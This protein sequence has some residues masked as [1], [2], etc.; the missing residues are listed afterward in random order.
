MEYRRYEND[1]FES[2]APG[3]PPHEGRGGHGRPHGR[4]RGRGRMLAYFL[5]LIVLNLLLA[6]YALYAVGMSMDMDATALLGESSHTVTEMFFQILMLA[7]PILLSVILNRILYWLFGGRRVFP[8]GTGVLAFLVILLVQVLTV[9]AVLRYGRVN[10]EKG[11]APIVTQI[12][13]LA[14]DT[15]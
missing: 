11:F 1:G 7:S 2:G 9:C 3:E 12:E 4:G 15:P 6:V 14:E 8:H 10:G 5:M 13:T